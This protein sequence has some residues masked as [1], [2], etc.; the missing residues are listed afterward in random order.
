MKLSLA[1]ATYNE[2]ENIADCLSSCRSL[3]DEMVVVDGSSSDKTAEIA[4]KHGAKVLV[5]NNPA[6]FHI[7]KQ[8]AIDASKGEWILQLDADERVTPELA[9]EIR[10]VI[11]MS[12]SEL[13]EYQNKLSGK[14]LFKRHQALVQPLLTYEVNAGPYNAFFIPRLNY[15]LGKYL[16]YGG[17]Y[18]DGAI[19]L[20]RKGKA[21]LPCRDVHEIMEVEGKTGWLQH[22]LKHIDSPNFKR[23]LERNSRYID[24]MVVDM[25]KLNTK[26][27]PYNFVDYIFLKPISWFLMTTF[28]HKGIL[29]G[30]QGVVFS[31]FS[32]LRFPR[33]YWRFLKLR[34]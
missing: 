2:A 8:K 20:I 31:F 26:K 13:E 7:N 12:E 27:N 28:R 4:H 16:R 21:H 24:R 18:P 6:M 14:D 17:V 3:V 22:P 23:Y 5:T 25:K 19:R 9:R 34:F 10:Q 32:A 33:A 1:V 30:W 15:F 11:D 29:D